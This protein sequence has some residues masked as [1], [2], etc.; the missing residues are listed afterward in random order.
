MTETKNMLTGY[1]VIDISQFV[2]GPTCTRIMAELGAD[3]IK[4]E[5]VPHGDRGRM[6]GLRPIAEE[7]RKSSASTY[8]FQHN[9]SKKSLALDIKSEVGKRL[10]LDLVVKCDVLVENF[11]PG[12]M[13]RMGFAYDELK[14]INPSLIMCSISLA[15]QEGE[16]CTQPGF[17][18][19][20]AAYAGI[21]SALGESD[22]APTQLPMAIGDSATGVAAAMAVGYALLHRER[23]GEGQ[24]IESTLLDSYFHMHE[25]NIPKVAIRGASVLPERSG[26]IHPDG[27]PTGVFRIGED[28]F[29]SIMVMPYQWPQIV[30]ALGQPDLADDPRFATPRKRRD[31]KEALHK[32]VEEW[33][34]DFSTREDALS[35]LHKQRI[36][37]APVL[38]LDEAMAHPHH[39]ERGTIR[40]VHDQQLGDFQI[41]GMPVRFSRWAPA[42]RLKA[43]L[44]GEHNEEIL[45]DIL[46]LDDARISELYENK[47]LVQ[48]PLVA[49]NN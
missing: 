6:S 35:A 30:A 21:T 38:S 45:K 19:M 48:D 8:Y 14:K 2:A 23:T 42:E 44:L 3:V 9:H 47:V 29:I 16:L 4:V 17:D 10:F 49:R 26:S 12:V 39:I 27:G 36:P 43:A 28:Q 31:N 24:Y 40:N 25:V 5:L 15:G 11:S 41:P 13:A 46:G 32:I 7:Y 1:R 20:G 34:A 18:Y 22:R 37:C 33:L